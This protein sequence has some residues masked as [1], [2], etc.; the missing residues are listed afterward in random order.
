MSYW[1]KGSWYL[2]FQIWY[3]KF[4]RSSSSLLHKFWT[5]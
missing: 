4:S 2:F 5:S 3:F 1:S